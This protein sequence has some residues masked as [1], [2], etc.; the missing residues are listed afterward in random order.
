MAEAEENG[1]TRHVPLQL[2]SFSSDQLQRFFSGNH[3]PRKF[4]KRSRDNYEEEEEEGIELSLGLSM[5]GR[6]GVDPNRSMKLLRS[7]SISDFMISTVEKN[8]GFTVPVATYTSL[9]RTCSLPTETE[10]EWRKRKELQSLRRLEAKRKRVE[11]LKNVRVVREKLELEESCEENGHGLVEINGNA[12]FLGPVGAV[13]LVNG[14]IGGVGNGHGVE[15]KGENGIGLVNQ[16]GINGWFPPKQPSSQGSMGSQGSGS[17]GISDLESQPIH[18][19]NKYNDGR[20]F[21]SAQSLPL[22]MEPRSVVIPATTTDKPGKFTGAAME[23][24]SMKVA[25]ADKEAKKMVR[26]MMVDMPCVTTKGEGPNGR[27]IEGILYRY[28]KGEEVRIVC[29]CHGSFLTPAEFVKHA[30]GG[31]VPNP[32]KHIVVNPSRFL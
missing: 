6:F 7:S 20:R 32:L 16:E 27:K 12:E 2:G 19:T 8:M 25:V 26:N 15:S 3:F 18:G 4:E 14:G 30:G 21:V 9:T 22:H 5:N 11:K 28:R 1:K 29:V 23:N 13:N 17:S 24:P 10:E 31:D